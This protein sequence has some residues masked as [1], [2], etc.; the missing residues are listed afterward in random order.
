MKKLILSLTLISLLTVSLGGVAF[1]QSQQEPL[2]EVSVEE[3]HGNVPAQSDAAQSMYPA[4]HALVMAMTENHLDYD[5]EDPE[6]LWT[7][8]Y[9]MLSLYGQMD[10]RA[11]LTDDTLILPGEVVQDYASALYPDV[12]TLPEIPS[13]ISERISYRAADHTYRLARGDEGLSQV[14]V[15][16]PVYQDSG[17]VVV[18]GALKSSDDG[19][20]LRAFQVTL[21]PRDCMF[22]YII[23]DLTFSD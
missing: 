18:D 13:P 6:F 21:L 19:S 8:L 20:T 14:T 23:T 22:G 12:S 11:E 1:A 17:T 15:D 7:S 3:V 9:Y 2:S 4:I 10:E 5:P 16:S